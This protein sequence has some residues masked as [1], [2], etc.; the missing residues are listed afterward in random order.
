MPAPEAKIDRNAA[1]VE[2]MR[3]GVPLAQIAREQG[4]TRQRIFQIK[5]LAIKRGELAT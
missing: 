3:R 5:L 4:V 1:I 2:A